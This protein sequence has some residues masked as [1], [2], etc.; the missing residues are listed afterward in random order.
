M[1]LWRSGAMFFVII[2][3]FIFI[4]GQPHATHLLLRP[5]L[6]E[7]PPEMVSKS[8][9]SREAVPQ[10]SKKKHQAIAPAAWRPLGSFGRVT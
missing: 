8:R 2:I 9:L 10:K 6:D 7:C 1:T 3:I 4:L 5:F